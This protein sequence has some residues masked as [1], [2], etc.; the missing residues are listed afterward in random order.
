MTARQTTLRRWITYGVL[1]LI[2]ALACFALAS[3][4]FA[5]RDETLKNIDLVLSNYD[6]PPVSLD[7]LVTG[8]KTVETASLEWRQVELRGHYDESKQLLVRNRP[9][10]SQPGFELL[11]PLVLTDGSVFIVDRGW[12]PTG[13]KQDFPDAIP[14]AP[15]GEVAVTVHLKPS[16]PTIAG[17]GSIAGQVATVNLEEVAKTTGRSTFT[18]FYGLLVSETPSVNMG[19]LLPAQKPETSEGMHLSYALQWIIFALLAFFALAWA[20]RREILFSREPIDPADEQS[21]ESSARRTRNRTKNERRRVSRSPSDED[22]E[23]AIVA[24]ANHR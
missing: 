18:H 3:W 7:S 9:R 21:G 10:E 2:F 17:R 6:A 11:T 15:A 23:D 14:L 22:I 12:L 1:T 24:S 20:I 13:E 16:E 8:S 4:Q 5:R 19:A